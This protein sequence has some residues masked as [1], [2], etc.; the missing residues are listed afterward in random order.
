MVLSQMP[1]SYQFCAHTS[2]CA[3]ECCNREKHISCEPGEFVSEFTKVFIATEFIV[4]KRSILAVVA[5]L[6]GSACV[7]DDGPT[8]SQLPPF[9]PSDMTTVA[10]VG[11]DADASD[12]TD[13]GDL[14]AADASMPV[15]D[16]TDPV[17]M[18]TEPDMDEEPD[19]PDETDM[20]LPG[21]RGEVCP[22][23]FPPQNLDCDVVGQNCPDPDT[24]CDITVL[25]DGDNNVIGFAPRCLSDREGATYSIAVGSTCDQ[26]SATDRCVKGARC[27]PLDESIRCRQL[28]VL[29]D[30]R[31][32]DTDDVARFCASTGMDTLTDNGLGF[33]A[34]ACD[35]FQ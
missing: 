25:R 6:V 22:G 7:F 15:E 23:E 19:M 4:L 20:E 16:M 12:M 28:C 34:S 35:A 18:D 2:T 33:C 5:L 10:D 30:A 3:G 24:H 26:A 17:D 11:A 14:D 1:G 29:S 32:C 27:Q 13:A 8:L 9:E 21:P 31:G